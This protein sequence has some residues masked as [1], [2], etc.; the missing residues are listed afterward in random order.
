MKKV[1]RDPEVCSRYRRVWV[2]QQEENIFRQLEH[3][4]ENFFAVKGRGRQI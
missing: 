4:S 2:L 3:P 1:P